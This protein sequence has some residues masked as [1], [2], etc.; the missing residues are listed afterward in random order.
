MTGEGRGPHRPPAIRAAG[1]QWFAILLL[2]A[3]L[4]LTTV[5]AV[6]PMASY[7][8]IALG[9]TP[10]EI[11]LLPAAFAALSL[12]IAVPAGRWID[13]IGEPPFLA[14]GTTL[15]VGSVVVMIATESIMALVAAQAMLGLGHI[16]NIIAAQ[17][18]IANRTPAAARDGRYGMYSVA[19]SV[20]QLIGPALAGAV[21]GA[22]AST[23]DGTVATTPVFVAA[24][25]AGIPA[26]IMAAALVVGTPGRRAIP[27]DA[28]GRGFIPSAT[29]VLR[30]PTM[31][32]AILV[33]VAVIL[34][35][36]LLIAYLPLYGETRGLSVTLV[37]ALLSIRA[38][39]SLASRLAMGRL[40]EAV[41]RGRLLVGSAA[42]AALGLAALPLVDAPWALVGVMILVGLGLGFGQPM[43]ISWVASRAPAPLRATALGMRLTGN[44]L[45]QLTVPAVVGLA[46]GVAGVSI[47]FW[48]MA[49]LLLASAAVV[50]R[51]PF[52][53]APLGEG[54]GDPPEK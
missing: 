41:G 13:R 38:A 39:S 19:A 54:G 24:A 53:V 5:N 36:D 4:M 17:S 16:I 2:I 21:A 33:S 14:L 1:A 28:R 52:D 42:L 9:A 51:T 43:T 47:V 27:E 25:L 12:V 34:T 22:F 10:F 29:E 50:M 32:P 40:I 7:R 44:R 6:R 37:G 30:M 15:M 46:A 11:G 18:M 45:G 48:S 20:G 3:I 49:A 23:T 8:A 35:I 26:I 31:I